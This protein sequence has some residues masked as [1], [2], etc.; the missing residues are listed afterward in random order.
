ML[1][2]LINIKSTI[3]NVLHK[4]LTLFLSSIV[5]TLNQEKRYERKKY[6]NN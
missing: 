1:L 4:L 5:L 3:S 2:D 6:L